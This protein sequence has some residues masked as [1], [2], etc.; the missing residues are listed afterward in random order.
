M[1]IG[2]GALLSLS[3][4]NRRA[5][6]YQLGHAELERRL[7]EHVAFDPC[8]Y[9]LSLPGVPGADTPSILATP[10]DCVSGGG[11]LIAF[12]S[13]SGDITNA[14]DQ[15]VYR[16]FGTQLQRSLD[17]GATWVSL[18]APEVTIDSFQLYVIGSAPRSAGDLIQPRV[19][20][21][22]SGSA[23][24]PGG[25]TN[26]YRPGFGDAAPDRHMM[27]LPR[28]FTLIETMVAIS[29]LLLSLV[30]PLSI[31]SKSLQSA[32]AARDEVTAVVSR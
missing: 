9:Q 14:N 13:S 21:T 6:A 8:R 4:A 22:I 23:P 26:L 31:A 19:L 2:V 10:Q 7:G 30:G 1:M 28:A 24:V 32:Y 11:V 16:I 20:M 3:E 17:S 5:E 15:I 18:T 29:V 12:E 27:K 25:R